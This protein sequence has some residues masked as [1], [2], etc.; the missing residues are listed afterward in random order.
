MS[1]SQP[2]IVGRFGAPYG[3]KGW[4]RV[5]S[6]TDPPQ[7]I[8]NYR[9]WYVSSQR[10]WEEVGLVGFLS[11]S[12]GFAAGLS[13]IADRDAATLLSGRDIC[14]DAT[15]LPEPGP[16]EIYWKDLIGLLAESPTGDRLG[17]IT[18][19]MPAGSHDVLVIESELT[20][21]PLL[22]PFHKDYVPEVD[23]GRGRLVAD[24]SAL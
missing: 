24:V 20:K 2:V 21:E 19:L 11:L 12:K 5:T 22:V 6:F 1:P 16:D 14:I 17:R 8:E 4:L 15:L 10:G 9:P 3:I 18:G 23:I 7:N 13:N